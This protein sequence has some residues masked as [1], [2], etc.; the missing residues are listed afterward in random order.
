M[1][2]EST[3]QL[4][5]EIINKA[6]SGYSQPFRFILFWEEYRYYRSFIRST[7]LIIKTLHTSANRLFKKY[8]KDII[9]GISDVNKLLAYSELLNIIAFYENDLQ[10]VQKMLAEYEEYLGE[11]NFWHAFFGGRRI[12]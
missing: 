11:G 6:Q 3:K 2:D 4:I 10:T 9:A 12:I 1:N 8:C 5:A 7:R